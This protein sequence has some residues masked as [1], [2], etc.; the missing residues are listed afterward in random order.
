[1]KWS[2][3]HAYASV[4]CHLNDSQSNLV[5][6]S[7]SW[8]HTVKDTAQSQKRDANDMR[9]KRPGIRTRTSTDK[10]SCAVVVTV[11]RA[12]GKLKRQ[13]MTFRKYGKR[14]ILWK[15]FVCSVVVCVKVEES[16]ILKFLGGIW[17]AKK[18]KKRE[19]RYDL[20]NPTLN[21]PNGHWQS[22]IN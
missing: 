18:K 19:L 17:R 9:S 12:E 10:S 21:F 22:S 3:C 13:K 6:R 14:Q 7:C 20:Q 5:F 15:S 2:G 11:V 1:M 16:E 4:M 8:L